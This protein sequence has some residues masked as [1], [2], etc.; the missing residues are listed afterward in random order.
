MYLRDSIVFLLKLGANAMNVSVIRRVT[1]RQV[2]E[3]SADDHLYSLEVRPFVLHSD[4]Q[5]D[6]IFSFI[7]WM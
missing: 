1:R 7:F 2:D 6:A 3:L 5:K 4:S